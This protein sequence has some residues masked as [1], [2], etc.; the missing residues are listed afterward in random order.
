MQLRDVLLLENGKTT[1]SYS[2]DKQSLIKK[3]E[4]QGKC[5][6]HDL[7]EAKQE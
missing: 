2:S 1:I 5:M 4:R 6:L 7:Y 3:T